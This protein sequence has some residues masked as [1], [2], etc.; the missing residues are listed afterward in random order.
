MT[1]AWFPFYQGDF[2]RDTGDLSLNQNGAYV[3]LLFF[4]YASG[5]PLPSDQSGLYRI[6]GAQDDGERAAVDF[7]V[8]RFFVLRDGAYHQDRADREIAKRNDLHERHS[9]AGR[10]RWQKPSSSL[11]EAG[12]EPSM[13]QAYAKPQPQPQPQEEKRRATAPAAPVALV[14]VAIWL[15]FVEMRKKIRKP[16]TPKAVQLIH[17]ELQRLKDAGHGPVEVLEQSIRNCWQDVF[18]VR[19]DRNNERAG[20]ARSFD[21]ARR[22]STDASI[23]RVAASYAGRTDASVTPLPARPGRDG[24]AHVRP[25]ASGSPAAKV[26]EGDPASVGDHEAHADDCQSV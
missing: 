4:Y 22:E 24:D 18:P 17:R 1:D 8:S 3:K 16:M 12:Y 26:K 10:K 25:G 21:A 19:G 23:K 5:N 9:N 6:A 13:S 15:E 20:G 7:V 14:P 2:L 11:A